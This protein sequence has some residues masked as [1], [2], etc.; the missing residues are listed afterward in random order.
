MPKKVTETVECCIC[1]KSNPEKI[2]KI[3]FNGHDLLLVK[4]KKCGLVYFSPRFSRQYV[5]KVYSDDL[6]GNSKYY[7]KT[8]DEDCRSFWGRLE[9]AKKQIK[10]KKSVLDIGSSTG[11]FLYCAKKFGFKK[12]QGT[13]LNKKS[14]EYCRKNFGFR[15]SKSLPKRGKFSLVNMSDIIE[16]LP[17]PLNFMKSV[18][19]RVSK[20]G[21]LLLTTPD[22]SKQITKV[23]NIKPEEHLYYF[24]KPT[25]RKLLERAGFEVLHIGNI[26]RFQRIESLQFS[27]TNK[28]GP[29][30]NI[31]SLIILL[32]LSML[33][34]ALIIRNLNSDIFVIARP[35][36]E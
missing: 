5:S 3:E 29:I 32:H 7:A 22:Y 23:M 13:E 21:I 4:C 17:R 33:F 2:K 10:S 6:L 24:T 20:D 8:F 31:L 36:K 11:T 1:G 9:L 16:H 28:S 35:R 14:S 19:K 27:S 30:S 18:K 15:V 26:S 25:L 12:L 34:E